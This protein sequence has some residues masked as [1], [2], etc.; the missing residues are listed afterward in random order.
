MSLVFQS[1]LRPKETAAALLEVR[2]ATLLLKGFEWVRNNNFRQPG[3]AEVDQFFAEVEKMG[4]KSMQLFVNQMVTKQIEKIFRVI[5]NRY[6]D[7]RAAGSSYNSTLIDGI[8]RDVGYA[9]YLDTSSISGAG[10]GVFLKGK[11]CAGTVLA[12]FPGEVHLAEYVTKKGYIDDLFPDDD[13]FL[14]RRYRLLVFDIKLKIVFRTDNV[15][16]D[17]RKSVDVN[18]M[19]CFP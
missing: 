9:P 5:D 11:V 8:V 13:F 2:R 16:I 17:G 1:F 12:L 15:I 18:D 19:T 6:D 3:A 14:M 7:S 10:S 4:M